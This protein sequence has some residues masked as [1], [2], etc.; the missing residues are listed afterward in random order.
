MSADLSAGHLAQPSET[1][2]DTISDSMS[3]Y[4]EMKSEDIAPEAFQ[5]LV[6]PQRTILVEV[7]CSPESRL[8]EEVRKQAGY[9]AAAVRCSHWNNCDLETGEG[10]KNVIRQIDELGPSSVWISPICGPYSPL[11]AINQRAE[12]QCQELEEKRKRALKQYVG[13]C[14]IFQYCIQKGIHVSWEWAERCQAWRLPMIQNLVKKYQPYFGVT[15]GCRV[16]LRDPKSQCLLHK[17]WKVMT[18]QQH[19]ADLLERRCKCPPGYRHAKCEGGNAGMTAYYT[20]EF[21]KLITKGIFREMTT[22]QVQRELEGRTTLLPQ[23]GLGT[24]CVCDQLKHHEARIHCGFCCSSHGDNKDDLGQCGGNDPVDEQAHMQQQLKQEKE[25]HEIQRKLYLL[26]AATGHCSTRH[27]IQAL[28]RRGASKEVIEQAKQ[29][30]CSVCEESKKYNHKHVATLEPI[31]PKLSVVSADG[32]KWVHPGTGEEHEFAI[33]IDEGSR[34]RVARILAHGKKQTMNAAKFLDYFQEGWTQYFGNPQ[35]LRLDPSGVFRS[36]HVENFCDEKGIFLEVIPGEAHW[37]LGICER[38]IDSVKSV[39][40]RLAQADHELSAHAALTEAIRT[41]NHREIIRGYSPVQHMLGLAPDETGR[42]IRSLAGQQVEQMLANPSEDFSKDIERQKQAEQALSEWQAQDRINRA[43][44][45]R[46]QRVFDYRPGDLVYFWR[47]Q[48]KRS[49]VGKNGMFLGPARILATETKRTPEGNLEPGSSI[50]CVRGRRLI[51]CCPEQLR[52]ATH[53]EEV[54]EHITQTQDDETPWLF[55]RV[56][57][58]LGGNEYWDVSQDQPTDE[59]WEMAQ[60]PETSEQ[61]TH[62]RRYKRPVQPTIQEQQEEA[63][64]SRPR[65]RTTPTRWRGYC[66]LWRTTGGSLV[67]FCDA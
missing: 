27:M 13:A 47:K 26:H 31:P 56:A 50:W 49:G 3:R 39:M 52:R 10:V 23:F 25:Q 61:P 6:Y 16:N 42:F 8:T 45:S 4:M 43:M 57:A 67:E 63:Q 40:T 2:S 59:D 11:Q 20:P 58:E 18:T 37:K 17:G 28:Q 21:V 51:K 44:Q 29:F 54:L 30:K 19:L 12:A 64:S 7:A 53:R 32:G 1:T 22:V 46:A 9:E 60:D 5:S 55:P 35:T 48:V 38:A 15:H 66:T 14:C 34:F 36:T 62:R 65:P 41:C 33:I 24:F